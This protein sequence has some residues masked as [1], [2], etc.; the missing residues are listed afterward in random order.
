[1][2]GVQ[3]FRKCILV[4]NFRIFCFSYKYSFTI[5]LRLC[6]CGIF[7]AQ[8]FKANCFESDKKQLTIA[9]LNLPNFVNSDAEIKINTY[10]ALSDS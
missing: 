7:T 8:Q 1:M 9:D 5:E 2:T 3:K 6:P 4:N 10:C